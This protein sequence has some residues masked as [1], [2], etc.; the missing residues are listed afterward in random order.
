MWAVQNST[1]YRA[2]R[3]WVRDHTGREVWLVAVRA[4]FDIRATGLTLAAP[5]DQSDVNIAGNLEYQIARLEAE[6]KPEIDLGA[7]REWAAKRISEQKSRVDDPRG[8]AQPK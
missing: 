3:A 7:L 1:P 2:N 5:E 4:R 8:P 6:L